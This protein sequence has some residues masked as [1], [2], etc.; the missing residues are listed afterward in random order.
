MTA[1]MGR[2]WYML[3]TALMDRQYWADLA[4][5]GFLSNREPQAVIWRVA[6]SLSSPLGLVEFQNDRRCPLTHL[7]RTSVRRAK[8]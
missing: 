2:P 4:S 8:A 5:H 1:R 6:V 3:T 7:P